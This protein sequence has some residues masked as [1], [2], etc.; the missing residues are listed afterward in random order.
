MHNSR[1]WSKINRFC[2]VIIFFLRCPIRF[3]GVG[4]EH[5]LP[6]SPSNR[7]LP[8]RNIVCC[9]FIYNFKTNIFIRSSIDSRSDGNTREFR[10]ETSSP[11]GEAELGFELAISLLKEKKSTTTSTRYSDKIWN[12]IMFKWPTA[13]R[14][15][16]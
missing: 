11:R 9:A 10:S 15:Q 16:S 7:C 12:A 2:F 14:S 5:A 8:Q 13:S 4:I 6:S 1:F 3:S